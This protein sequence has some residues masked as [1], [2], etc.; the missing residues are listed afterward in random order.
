MLARR[1]R[2][3]IAMLVYDLWSER[4]HRIFKNELLNPSDLFRRLQYTKEEM[5]GGDDC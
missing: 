1:K 2:E 4:N 3:M 5:Q